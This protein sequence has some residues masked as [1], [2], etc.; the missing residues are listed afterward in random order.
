MGPVHP[1]PKGAFHQEAAHVPDGAEC[2]KGYKPWH[3]ALD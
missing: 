2:H 1:Y 3:F